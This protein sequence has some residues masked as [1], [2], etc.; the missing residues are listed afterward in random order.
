[1]ESAAP[2]R[3]RAE[4]PIAGGHASPDPRS[5]RESPAGTLVHNKYL[6]CEQRAKLEFRRLREIFFSWIPEASLI[7]A[8]GGD[9]RPLFFRLFH[10]I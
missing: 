9:K 4:A 6:P 10:H 5:A 7:V 8:T 1:V 3:Y 2:C